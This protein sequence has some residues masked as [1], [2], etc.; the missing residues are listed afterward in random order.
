MTTNELKENDITIDITFN[1]RCI[2]VV[3]MMSNEFLMKLP[4]FAQ[5]DL[6][7]LVASVLGKFSIGMM[8]DIRFA[9]Q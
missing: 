1:S 7:Y 3:V 9:K 6:I 8:T 5:F 4:A 2:N